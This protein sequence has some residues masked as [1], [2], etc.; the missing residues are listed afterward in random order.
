MTTITTTTVLPSK[1][2]VKLSFNTCPP[3][4]K[5]KWRKLLITFKRYHAGK[6]KCRS[7]WIHTE[8]RSQSHLSNTGNQSLKKKCTGEVAK[9]PLKGLFLILQTEELV[10][11]GTLISP[12]TQLARAASA[13]NQ[14][15]YSQSDTITLKIISNHRIQQLQS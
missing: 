12:C 4:N 2:R 5:F 14:T 11:V 1:T 7:H 13:R 3:Y 15:F 6:T 10:A 9:K 8:V